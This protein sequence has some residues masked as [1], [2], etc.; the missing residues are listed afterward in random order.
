M[1]AHRVHHPSPPCQSSPQGSSRT[2]RNWTPFTTTVGVGWLYTILT[3]RIARHP[4]PP[5]ADHPQFLRALTWMP[6]GVG[7]CSG[8]I[9]SNVK[10]PLHL[11]R[12]RT[13]TTTLPQPHRPLKKHLFFCVDSRRL[14]VDQMASSGPSPCRIL[15]SGRFGAIIPQGLA[16]EAETTQMNQLQAGKTILRAWSTPPRLFLRYLKQTVP[17]SLHSI[18]LNTLQRWS[19]IFSSRQLIAVNLKSR[20]SNKQLSRNKSIELCSSGLK[21][22]VARHGSR[23]PLQ[24]FWG[25]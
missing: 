4:L 16:N 14:L 21:S 10:A 6:W 17:P 12:C 7:D 23:W 18:F 1:T 2:S 19:Q 20:I 24:V 15:E 8:P 5:P 9:L 22:G 3:S 13:G 25:S 11:L